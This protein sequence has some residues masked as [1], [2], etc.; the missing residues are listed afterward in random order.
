MIKCNNMH[1]WILVISFHESRLQRRFSSSK[2]NGQKLLIVSIC[3]KKGLQ[4]FSYKTWLSRSVC[5]CSMGSDLN[6]EYFFLRLYFVT[7]TCNSLYRIQLFILSHTWYCR[8]Y[9][10]LGKLWCKD[11]VGL[12]HEIDPLFHFW[13]MCQASKR[14]VNLSWS[15]I[16]CGLQFK[17]VYIYFKLSNMDIWQDF[18]KI[19]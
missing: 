15:N 14:D 17:K 16:W 12:F 13:K 11:W 7:R 9:L 4:P 3:Q 1:N 8:G 6:E 10:Q 5:N 19:T 18:S 2:Y